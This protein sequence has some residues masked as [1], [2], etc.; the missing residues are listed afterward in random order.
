MPAMW[1][2][3]QF[4]CSLMIKIL[5]IPFTIYKIIMYIN[6]RA[7]FSPHFGYSTLLYLHIFIMKTYYCI[8]RSQTFSVLNMKNKN[9]R[10]LNWSFNVEHL[11]IIYLIS[12]TNC[13]FNNTMDYDCFK[14]SYT[15]VVIKAQLI[16]FNCEGCLY[17]SLYF[18]RAM[19]LNL[20]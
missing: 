6:R 14:P 2:Q 10:L 7:M 3:M 8:H 4:Y 19:H 20:L 5:N 17:F 18:T 12:Q 11:L 16:G 1:V 15:I 13:L 9:R